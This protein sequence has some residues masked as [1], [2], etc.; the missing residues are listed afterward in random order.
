MKYFL[1]TLGVFFLVFAGYEFHW[2]NVL[3][4]E[5]EK[6]M[7]KIIEQRE[8]Q[9]RFGNKTYEVQY[10]FIP[11]G[12][13]I[14]YRREGV[15]GRDH[16]WSTIPEEVWKE[17]KTDQ[18]LS[19]IFLPKQP[20]MNLPYLSLSEGK[21]DLWAMLFLGLFLVFIALFQIWIA[22]NQGTVGHR[23]ARSIS[24]GQGAPL[25]TLRGASKPEPGIQEKEVK[26]DRKEEP[27]QVMKKEFP[28]EWKGVFKS[29]SIYMSVLIIL[30]V[31][32]VIG[33][34]YLSSG[35]D[36]QETFG[37]TSFVG[38]LLIL[39]IL[40]ILSVGISFLVASWLRLAK[41]SIANGEIHGRNAWFLRNRIP[42]SDLSG[43]THFSH[44][45]IEAIVVDS[46]SHGKVFISYRTQGLSELL[47]ILD[48]Y[49][50]E[51]EADLVQLL[52]RPRSR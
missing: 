3:S 5:G 17:I 27:R 36:H 12:G 35:F 32:L 44:N 8:S 4:D 22:I 6:I 26:E 34:R 31:T 28:V 52:S 9:D 48:Q 1:L 42:L 41:I 25:V 2:R 16:L 38:F 37:K 45:G 21:F 14:S 39:A 47:E 30:S 23:R 43:L 18:R 20:S 33:V 10:Q 7:A 13:E 40:A 51:G 15:L 19:V 11:P 24:G 50:P 46:G 49:L 29:L